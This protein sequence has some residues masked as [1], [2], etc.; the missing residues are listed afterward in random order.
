MALYQN[1]WTEFSL[2]KYREF[3]DSLHDIKIIVKSLTENVNEKLN[4]FIKNSQ[5]NIIQCDLNNLQQNTDI[6]CKDLKNSHLQHLRKFDELYNL[7]LN[8][9]F[10][11]EKITPST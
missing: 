2:D 9:H 11:L 6:N 8:I 5:S 7:I 3:Q 1:Q 10:A 4:I